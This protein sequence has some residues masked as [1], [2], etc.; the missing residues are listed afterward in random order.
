MANWLKRL[1]LI[2][3]VLWSIP[4]S[5]SQTPWPDYMGG[6]SWTS[7]R[8]PNPADPPTTLDISPPDSSVPLARAAW[9]GIWKGWAC[10]HAACAVSLVVEKVSGDMADVIYVFANQQ[11]K[12]SPFRTQAAFAGDELHIS[13]SSGGAA[14]FRIRKDGN[15]DYLFLGQ[16]RAPVAAG[17]L[18]REQ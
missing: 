16:N 17:L 11:R 15:M 14:A 6:L 4:N 8:S 2:A 9:V 3:F 7:H 12:A 13:F 10:H 5:Y 1:L 18:R